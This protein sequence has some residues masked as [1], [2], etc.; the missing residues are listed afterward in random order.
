MQ[1]FLSVLFL[2]CLCFA[3]SGGPDEGGYYWYDQE[4]NAEFFNEN[5]I[6]ISTTGTYMGP[7]DDTFWFAG[8]LDFDFVF[9]GVEKD[10]VY[11]GSN[12]TIVFRN[13]YLGWGFTH[14]PALN[15]C[16]V[17]AL[18]APW[19][20]D[21]DADE[22]GGIYYQAFAD[23]FVVMWDAVP[24][25]VES[26]A[27][28]YYV[29]CILIG[30]ASPDGVTNSEIAFLYNSSS[31]EPEGSSGMQG[32]R[33]SGTELQYMPLQCEPGHWNLLTS[34]ADPFGTSSLAS[35]TWASIKTSL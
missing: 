20:C 12:G 21:L 24:P 11:I 13:V 3:S 23:H 34:S 29:T 18:V 1:S 32:T 25:W 10:S 6:D 14:F 9:Y 5:W 16:F 31:Y 27:A 4:E 26:G 2:V 33:Y 28:P 35:V 30:W 22:E 7:G 17:E 15:S 8:E 19:W